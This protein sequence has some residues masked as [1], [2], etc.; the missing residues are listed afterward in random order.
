M[1]NPWKKAFGDAVPKNIEERKEW[2]DSLEEICNNI[3]FWT[4]DADALKCWKKYLQEKIRLGEEKL[5]KL[6]LEID[7]DKI[8]LEHI[9][10]YEHFKKDEDIPIDKGNRNENRTE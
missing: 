1:E 4:N 8:L 3:L 5:R 9:E 6:K 10:I 2:I 7:G